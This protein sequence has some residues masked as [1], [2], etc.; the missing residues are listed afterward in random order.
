MSSGGEVERADDGL[1]QALQ[2]GFKVWFEVDVVYYPA[3]S[4]Y[5][6]VMM[7]CGPLGQFVASHAPCP[8]VRGQ[9]L[10]VLQHCQRPIERGEGEIEFVVQLLSTAWSVGG[11]K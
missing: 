9:H 5:H 3:L 7:T 8:V 6:V 10:G 2:F 1:D 4:A 11:T